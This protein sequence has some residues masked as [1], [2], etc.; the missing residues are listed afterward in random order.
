VWAVIVAPLVGIFSFG[1]EEE[2]GRSRAETNPTRER[3]K[4]EGKGF[5]YVWQTVY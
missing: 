5:D 3:L 1:Q 4:V 2:R